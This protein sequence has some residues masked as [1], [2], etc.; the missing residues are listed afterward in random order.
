MT[1]LK[2]NSSRSVFQIAP[3]HDIVLFAMVVSG[4]G[5]GLEIPQKTSKNQ[6]RYCTQ[7][8]AFG[9]RFQTGWILLRGGR[10]R[11]MR[12]SQAKSEG[13]EFGFE[14]IP[15]HAKEHRFLPRISQYFHC[16]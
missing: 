15:T 1:F 9:L 13:V 3:L 2:S 10:P 14:S 7:G 8:A 11:P 16:L 12:D 5:P 6:T 4:P